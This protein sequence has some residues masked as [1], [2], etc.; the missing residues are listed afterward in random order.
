MRAGIK[1]GTHRRLAWSIRARSLIRRIQSCSERR[2]TPR[3]RAAVGLVVFRY[4]LPLAVLYTAINSGQLFG[5]VECDKRFA[6]IPICL[7]WS[8][9]DASAGMTDLCI[10]GSRKLV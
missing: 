5:I 10:V 6:T 4:C 7:A 9:K 1:G 3:G 2:P 8:G